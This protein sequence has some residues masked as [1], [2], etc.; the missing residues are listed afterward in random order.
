M[1]GKRRELP[2]TGK[3]PVDEYRLLSEWREIALGV[4]W[5]PARDW[6]ERPRLTET[7]PV[8]RGRMI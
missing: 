6:A 2:W 4:E 3:E 7:K 8:K 5:D 1:S